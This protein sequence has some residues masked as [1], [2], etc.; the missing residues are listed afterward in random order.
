MVNQAQLEERIRESLPDA[1]IRSQDL[2][3]GGDHWQVKIRSNLFA[4]KSMVEQHQ[5][6][7]K[8]LGTWMQQEIHALSLDTDVID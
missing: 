2:T 3:G 8:A 1:Q 6:I 4:G 5:M 7:Y